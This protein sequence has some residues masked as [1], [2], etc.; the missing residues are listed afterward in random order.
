MMMD[1]VDTTGHNAT[2]S[3]HNKSAGNW[4][5]PSEVI[6]KM[7]ASTRRRQ[8]K[9]VNI[10]RE[11]LTL[12]ERMRRDAIAK[13]QARER[14]RAVLLKVH[15][16][17]PATSAECAKRAHE[18]TIRQRVAERQRRACCAVLCSELAAV[19]ASEAH[20]DT[21][22]DVADALAIEAVADVVVGCGCV[23]VYDHTTST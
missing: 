16:G 23:P 12:S 21:Y 8:Q 20:V 19:L 10:V 3:A 6:T 9:Q 14:R 17:I 15:A 13:R 4:R 1:V 11:C 7:L 18:K 22:L 2:S 5:A